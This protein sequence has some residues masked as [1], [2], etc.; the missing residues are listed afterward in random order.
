MS[1]AQLHR[2]VVLGFTVLLLLSAPLG[3]QTRPIVIQGGTLIDGTGRP[4][5]WPSCPRAGARRSHAPGPTARRSAGP[6]P[7]D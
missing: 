6:R 7:A 2:R 1:C 5:A 4:A 3:A